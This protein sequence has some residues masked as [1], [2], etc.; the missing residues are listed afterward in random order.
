M[1]TYLITKQFRLFRGDDNRHGIAVVGTFLGVSED[2]CRAISSHW[3]D[4]PQDHREHQFTR[5]LPNPLPYRSSRSESEHPF[6]PS[7]PPL[8]RPTR[9]QEACQCWA[10]THF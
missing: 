1:S 9:L 6:A 2:A 5:H 4:P 10:S 7:A 8:H 3:T